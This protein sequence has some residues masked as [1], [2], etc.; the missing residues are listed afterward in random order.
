MQKRNRL[1]AVKSGV[2]LRTKKG[3]VKTAEKEQ[4]TQAMVKN[5]QKLE[6]NASEKLYQ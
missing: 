3:S 4:V 2:G 1:S 5:V 6:K